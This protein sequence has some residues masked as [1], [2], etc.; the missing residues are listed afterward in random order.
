MTQFHQG[1]TQPP[2]VRADDAEILGVAPNT[3]QLLADGDTG[4]GISAARSKLGRGTDGP[5]P[6][7]HTSSPEIFFIIDGGLHVLC[8]EQVLTV[9]AGDYLLV[10][11]HTL[12]AFATPRDSGVDLLFLMPGV[13]RFEYFRLGDRISRGE[14]SRQ[15]LL[16]TQDR[17]DN[18]F[19]D[20]P[21]GASS[22]AA[23][24]NAAARCRPKAARH[25]LPE[26]GRTGPAM[27]T[28]VS[29]P[30][31]PLA[32]ATLAG[33]TTKLAGARTMRADAQ[34]FGFSYH[35]YRRIGLTELAAAAGLV[36]GLL[37]WPVGAAAAAHAARLLARKHPPL[38][39][40]LVPLAHRILRAKMGQT[41]HFELIPLDGQ[42]RAGQILTNGA[43]PA[44]TRI[45]GRDDV[46]LQAQAAQRDERDALTSVPVADAPQTGRTGHH[47]ASLGTS[48]PTASSSSV[49]G[50]ASDNAFAWA[51][52]WVM[53]AP[54]KNKT[55]PTAAATPSSGRP[56]PTSSPTAP[57]ILRTSSG[58][59]HERGTPTLVMLART[60]SA[61]RK[62][63]IASLMAT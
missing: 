48:E 31:L 1:H 51:R 25:R 50:Y 2:L 8:G 22:A 40:V 21:S 24:P 62:S 15:E 63:L 34:R 3:I 19:H 60:Q 32:A 17:F 11:P 18:H 29:I 42:P 26:M 58:T 52:M 61:R 33:G 35:A 23:R 46:T 57:A 59:S 53:I 9:G 5:P 30:P 14:A 28:A 47:E 43:Q 6:H 16:A 49:P 12:H 37:L 44:P 45:R 54:T 38:Q 56:I 39:G 4:G 41:A 55:R 7:Y 13:E 20:S 10:P 36:T 27:N